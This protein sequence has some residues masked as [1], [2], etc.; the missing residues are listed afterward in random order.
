MKFKIVIA[1]GL[2]LWTL[3]AAG[4]EVPIIVKPGVGTSRDFRFDRRFPIKLQRNYSY[5][6]V[7]ELSEGQ[8]PETPMEKMQAEYG[9]KVVVTKKVAG[10]YAQLVGVFNTEAMPEI[11][12]ELGDPNYQT[13]AGSKNPT[14]DIFGLPTFNSPKGGSPLPIMDGTWNGSRGGGCGTW[15]TMMCNRILGDTPKDKKPSKKEWN[16]VAKKIGQDANG[17]SFV[18]GRAKYYEG[19]GYCASHETFGGAA[20]DF[21]KAADM[22][23]KGCDLKLSFW[24]KSGTTFSN[25]HNEVVTGVRF[26]KDGKGYLTTNSWGKASTI[27]GG[28]NGGFAHSEDTPKGHFSGLRKGWPANSTSVT[29]EYVCKCDKLQSL[30]KFLGL[31]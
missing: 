9:D 19:K 4:Q 27:K 15:A 23:N 16:D 28:Q 3:L 31:R 25:G 12:Q 18:S 14:V 21:K 7:A 26:T 8:Y 1:I 20:S 13:C 17:S 6:Y 24:K 11:M 30:A 2:S 22:L 29:L 10:R 5:T